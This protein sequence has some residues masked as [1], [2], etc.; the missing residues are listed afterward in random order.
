MEEELRVY[1]VW[2]VNI[3]D[4]LCALARLCMAEPNFNLSPQKNAN[5][6][7][8][9]ASLGIEELMFKPDKDFT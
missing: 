7:L 3:V 2:K 9:E 6:D 5:W 4:M 8:A 1:I